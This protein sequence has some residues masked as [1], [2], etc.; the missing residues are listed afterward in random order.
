MKFKDKIL[1]CLSNLYKRKI[2]TLLAT[3]G[4]IVGTCAVIITVSL[5]IGM[6]QAQEAALA[7]MGDLTMITI[8]GYGISAD[9][10]QLDD[11]FLSQL[12]QHEHVVAMTPSMYAQ[13]GML[14]LTSGKYL[15]EGS[16]YGVFM[17]DLEALGYQLME[18]EFP[19]TYSRETVFFGSSSVYDFIDTKKKTN[20]RVW[21]G[22]GKDPFVDID[23]N[24]KV[25][26]T[27]PDNSKR[28][29]DTYKLNVAGMLMEDWNK[30]P[31]PS[32]SIFMDIDFLH[33][34]QDEYNRANGIKV[35]KDKKVS[36]DSVM[37]K[38]DD[39]NHVA[40]VEEYIQSF[41]FETYSMESIR[42]PLQEQAQQ[43]QLT[44]GSLGA[45]SLLVAAFGIMNTMIMSIYERTREIGVMKVL[46]CLVKDIRQVFLMEAGLIGFMGGVAG[47][48]VSY[49]FSF[50][51][52]HFGSGVSEDYWL[53]LNGQ[54]GTTSVIPIWLALAAIIFATIIGIVSGIYPANRAV[55]ISALAAIKQDQ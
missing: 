7:Q 21:E 9:Q 1:M 33:E 51:I 19:D 20:N 15:Y 53:V 36:Y 6:Q 18:G 16:I 5:G 52:N 40:E 43:E 10:Q 13:W 50:F 14:E 38:C 42:K 17:E 29:P 26:I 8:Y 54:G 24:F 46:G 34:L 11:D 27:V 28:K 22:S 48:V 4:V 25:S 37:V 39:M 12:R 3:V 47:T 35:D 49:V 44:L 32:Y 2:R 41:G 23:D 31:S 55:K 30:N 45:V